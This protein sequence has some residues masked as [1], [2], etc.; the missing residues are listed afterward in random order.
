MIALVRRPRR[1]MHLAASSGASW[2]SL[3]DRVVLP[4]DGTPTV[5]LEAAIGSI[6]DHAD[7]VCADCRRLILFAGYVGRDRVAALVASLVR[8][9]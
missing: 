9:A 7:T 2:L 1:K 3:C 8:A 4:I 6:D 5:S